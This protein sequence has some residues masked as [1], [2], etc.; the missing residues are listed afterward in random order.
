MHGTTSSEPRP[1]ITGMQR[2]RL[3]R[4]WAAGSDGQPLVELAHGQISVASAC[5]ELQVRLL[6]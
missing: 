3:V 6:L 4:V 5:S 1:P 2:V